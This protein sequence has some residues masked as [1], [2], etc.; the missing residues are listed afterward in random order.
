MRWPCSPSP[1]SLVARWR[2][3]AATRGR[4]T[5]AKLAM[6]VATRFEEAQRTCSKR[7][8]EARMGSN[9]NG[10]PPARWRSHDRHLLKRGIACE[11]ILCRIRTHGGFSSQ[12]N[13][14]SRLFGSA[15]AAI[16]RAASWRAR[17]RP[18]PNRSGSALGVGH[19]KRSCAPPAFGPLSLPDS[20][21][22][23]P[24]FLASTMASPVPDVHR[25]AR[26]GLSPLSCSLGWAAQADPAHS[27]I[28]GQTNLL[29]M[30]LEPDPSLLLTLDAV[31]YTCPSRS[32]ASVLLFCSADRAL[33]SPP[34]RT[35]A[36]RCRTQS[37][38]RRSTQP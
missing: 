10:L 12:V 19:R 31:C 21:P 35:S 37:P 36:R 26:E 13:S 20:P 15:A 1:L 5:L 7:A 4:P 33:A 38:P 27:G 32:P 3:N 8:I 22:P 24:P 29:L 34:R 23:P 18:N 30:A 11:T 2:A 9:R 28:T 17:S 16:T 14:P 6:C 25:L